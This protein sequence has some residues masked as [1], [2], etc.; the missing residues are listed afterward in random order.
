MRVATNNFLASWRRYPLWITLALSLILV[1]VET[2]A[3]SADH[4]GPSAQTHSGYGAEDAALS[5]APHEPEP[6]ENNLCSAA[7]YSK[8]LLITRFPRSETALASAG[9]LYKVEEQLPQLIGA[10]LSAHPAIAQVR[11]LPASFSNIHPIGTPQRAQQVRE[12][13]RTQNVQLVLSGEII[14]M[15]MARPNDTYTPSLASRARNGLAT[16]THLRRL[17]TRQRE[18]VFQM[19][20][21]DGIT[22]AALQ[23]WHYHNRGVWAPGRPHSVGF[24]SPRFWRTH[25]GKQVADTL[26][27]AST[28]LAGE[29]SCLP[30]ISDLETDT[31]PTQV[32][33]RSG[34]EQQLRTG[35]TLRLYQVVTRAIPG[36]YQ[37]HRTHLLDSQIE[38]QI[39]EAHATYSFGRLSEELDL[40]HG[41]YVALTAELAK[42]DSLA[43]AH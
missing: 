23:Q 15:S 37:L 6:I 30:L 9:H 4:M 20:L 17:D 31:G 41:R 42:Q 22:G 39:Q 35:D 27:L 40:R 28:E 26:A 12:L 7:R 25:Y 19:T 16:A 1:A 13:A 33:V 32:I 36:A 38:V 34:T 14:D 29:I 11:Y 8:N 24:G 2:L 21:F 43:R 3:E 5:P 18:F 10:Q